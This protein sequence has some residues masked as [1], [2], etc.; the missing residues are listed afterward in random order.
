MNHLKERLLDQAQARALY[1]PP[2][3]FGVVRVAYPKI[4]P[5]QFT[6]TDGASCHTGSSQSNHHS[7][8]SLMSGSS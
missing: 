6:P 3:L 4:W 5:R 7:G 1:P 8:L 2:P